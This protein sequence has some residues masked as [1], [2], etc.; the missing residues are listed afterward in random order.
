MTKPKIVMA[1]AKINLHLAVGSSRNDG[2]HTIA[3][4]FQAIS[5]CDRVSL[6]AIDGDE[7]T[8]ACECDCPV[9]KNT[10]WRA[11]MAFRRAAAVRV[12]IP[13]LSIVVE[14][15][16][17][18]GAGLGGGS[19]DAAATLIGLYRMFP[20]AVDRLELL[21]IAEGIGSDVPFFMESACAAVS[22]RGE[23]L[24][25]IKPRLD[26]AL[27]IVDPGFPIS[28]KDAYDRLDQA[29][30]AGRVPP[31]T[32]DAAMDRE[33]EAMVDSYERV[34]LAA[35]PFR[36]DFFEALVPDY[37]ALEAC[38]AELLASGAVFASMSGSG[39]VVFGIYASSDHAEHVR[40]SFSKRYRAYTAFPLARLH[41]S[42]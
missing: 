15:G 32:G 40:A 37:P 23:R 24:T 16:I 39:S 28:T 38:K 22:G 41:Q 21:R 8:L 17:P 31:A 34:Q 9:E 13:A 11:A 42:I 4:I 36:N 33:L 5:L 6:A 29:R 1:P 12:V 19:S 2:F 25:P 26:Y 27:V 3:S 14:K 10:A 35:W 30:A 7:T 18:A 20:G